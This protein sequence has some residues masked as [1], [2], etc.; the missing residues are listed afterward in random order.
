MS[1]VLLIFFIAVSEYLAERG[2]KEGDF[3]GRMV[4]ESIVHYEGW[5]K[6]ERVCGSQSMSEQKTG[7]GILEFPSPLLYLVQNPSPWD[8]AGQ[9]QGGPSFLCKASLKKHS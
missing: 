6:H 7:Q 3:F 5:G 9:T 8:G 2:L 1:S 4:K